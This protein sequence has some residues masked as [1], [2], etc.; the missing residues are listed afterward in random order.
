MLMMNDAFASMDNIVEAESRSE[1]EE[2]HT[3]VELAC[4]RILLR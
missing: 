1:V 3:D 2:A 4:E